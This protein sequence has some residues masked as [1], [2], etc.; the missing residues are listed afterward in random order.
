VAALQLLL[1][2]ALSCDGQPC[3]LLLKPV[4]VPA[5]PLELQG[6]VCF[7]VAVSVSA[8]AVA[9]AEAVAVAL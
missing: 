4:Q 6:F 1:K 2:L 7:C 8:L 5:V 9:A 3:V